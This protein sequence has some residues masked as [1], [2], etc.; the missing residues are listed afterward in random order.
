MHFRYIPKSLFGLCSVVLFLLDHKCLVPD[1]IVQVFSWRRGGCGLWFSSA[2]VFEHKPS[3]AE[4]CT[5][6]LLSIC[7]ESWLWLIGDLEVQYRHGYKHYPLWFFLQGSSAHSLPPAVLLWFVHALIWATESTSM[8][9][10]QYACSFPS[11]SMDYT[12]F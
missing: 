9:R 7:A 4:R 12:I 11:L 10:G 3:W 1:H 5:H 6:R 2:C 8:R